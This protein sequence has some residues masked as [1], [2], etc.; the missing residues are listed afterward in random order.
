M[1]IPSGFWKKI[2]NLKHDKKNAS[3]FIEKAGLLEKRD[4]FIRRETF[5]KNLQS[6]CIKITATNMAEM[7]TLD[8]NMVDGKMS[9]TTGAHGNGGRRQ[10]VPVCEIRV[11]DAETM[12]YDFMAPGGKVW[13]LA[14]TNCG[15]Y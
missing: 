10:K 1:G 11:A 2:P 7:C 12:I 8:E 9:V 6:R 13:V 15:T 3:Y 5:K 4:D 14:G